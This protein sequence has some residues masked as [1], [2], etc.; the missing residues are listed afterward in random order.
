MNILEIAVFNFKSALIAAGAGADRLELC[1]DYDTGGVTVKPDVLKKVRDA[2]YVPVFPII[3]PRAGSFVYTDD[4]Y[5]QIQQDVLLCK[6]L[7]FEGVVVGFLNDDNSIDVDK[8]QTIVELASP[9]AVTFHR[10][11][12]TCI[13]PLKSLEQII[14]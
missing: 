6:Q 13:N 14:Q 9:L 8:T 5:E 3:R 7:G 10:A 2:V 4:E 12:D 11:F 1:D